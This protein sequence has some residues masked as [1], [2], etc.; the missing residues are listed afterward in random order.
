[1][2]GAC[3]R[4]WLGAGIEIPFRLEPR[5]Q[6]LDALHSS[7]ELPDCLI[8]LFE[9]GDS[10][11]SSLATPSNSHRLSRSIRTFP[12]SGDEFAAVPASWLMS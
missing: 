8:R 6:P 1:M 4:E 5:R 12:S 7:D 3:I 2:S 11:P 10:A 9:D